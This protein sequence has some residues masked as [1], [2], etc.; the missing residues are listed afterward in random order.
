[1]T[2]RADLLEAINHLDA[3]FSAA[4]QLGITTLQTAIVALSQS[5]A[6][7]RIEQ[8][9]RNATFAKTDDLAALRGT[10]ASHDRELAATTGRIDALT[11]NLASYNAAITSIRDQQSEQERRISSNALHDSRAETAFMK[12]WLG[13]IILGTL[14]IGGPILTAIAEHTIK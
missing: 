3:K 2:D 5:L 4:L 7:T 14:G 1:M 9:K 6:D 10:L 11:S 8:E 12:D 13:W